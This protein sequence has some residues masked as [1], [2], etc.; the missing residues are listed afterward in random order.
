MS[1]VDLRHRLASTLARALGEDGAWAV[2]D[3]FTADQDD[4]DALTLPGWQRRLHA[5]ARRVTG[6]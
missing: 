1:D 5:W 6:R 2:L 4:D 3:Q